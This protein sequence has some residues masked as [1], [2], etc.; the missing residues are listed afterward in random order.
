MR[1]HIFIL[2]FNHLSSGL[3]K[4]QIGKLTYAKGMF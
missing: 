1:K 2:I 3:K 4:L